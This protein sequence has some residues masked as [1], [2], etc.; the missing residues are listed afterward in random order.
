MPAASAWT[1]RNGSLQKKYT[2]FQPQEW[3]AQDPLEPESYYRELRDVLSRTLPN[4]FGGNEQVAVALTGGLD[5]RVI[6]A[7]QKVPEYSLPCY[8]FGGSIRDSHD[9]EIARNVARACRQSHEVI[10][11]GEEFLSRFPY[12]AERSVYLG[13]GTIGVSNSPDLY[14]SERARKIAPA[15]IVGTWGS[16][17]LNLAITFKPSIPE[18]GM[19]NKEFLVYLKQA[20]ETY[21]TI[22]RAH[23]TTFVAFRQT[24]WYQYGIEALEQ[25]QLTIRSPFLANDFVRTVYRAPKPDG[26]DVR[27]RLI[28]DGNPTLARISSDRGVRPADKHSVID[29]TAKFLRQF[30][31]KAEYA[32]DYGMPDW[33]ACA[34]HLSSPLRLDRLFLGRHKFLHFRLWYRDC[35]SDYVQQILLD[36]LTLSRAYVQ[37][38]TVDEI[39]RHHV[40]G[41]RNHTAAIHTLLTL[42]LLNRAFA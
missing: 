36:R 17:L 33:L 40:R 15:K 42:E 9:V 2:Y 35:L 4:Y 1:F 41:G 31:F 22:R 19:F 20:E 27:R 34:D 32:F 21:A 10:R 30:T 25:T 38:Q 39:V 28:S 18:P 5:T 12:Y 23:P 7:W 16:E 13:E 3:E 6:M 8:T 11:V 26:A 37:K 14:I 29:L 24:P